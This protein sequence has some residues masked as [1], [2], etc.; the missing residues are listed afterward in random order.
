VISLLGTPTSQ[1]EEGYRYVEYY[2]V[3]QDRTEAYEYDEIII[4]F[5][6]DNIRLIEFYCSKSNIK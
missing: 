4:S 3:G 1:S 2:D 6:D 5:K